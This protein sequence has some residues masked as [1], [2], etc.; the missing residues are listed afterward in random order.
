M[1]ESAISARGF[2]SPV[3]AVEAASLR[4]LVSILCVGRR[5][6]EPVADVAAAC[7]AVERALREEL[8]SPVVGC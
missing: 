4:L 2:G 3:S 5:S 1:S 6:D 7:L 8:G